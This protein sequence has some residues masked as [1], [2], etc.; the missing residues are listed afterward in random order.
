MLAQFDT[1]RKSL[2]ASATHHLFLVSFVNVFNVQLE[3]D[4]TAQLFPTLRT[5]DGLLGS[6]LVLGVKVL[7]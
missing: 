1:R 6:S 2:A 5:H 7:P 3:A 4:G